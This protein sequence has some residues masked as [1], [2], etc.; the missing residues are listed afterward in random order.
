M[1]DKSTLDLWHRNYKHPYPRGGLRLYPAVSRRGESR[2]LTNV[3]D[4][5][6]FTQLQKDVFVNLFSE[7]QKASKTYD[8]IFLDIDDS[9]IKRSFRL[10][11]AVTHK[12]ERNGIKHY[13]I[14]FSGSK[15]FH[16]YV[17]FELQFLSSYREA[18][19][20]WLREIDLIKYVD[21]SAIEHNRVTRLIGTEN[22]K[23][24]RYCIYL[25]NEDVVD[26]LDLSDIL[27]KA[28][29]NVNVGE[30]RLQ[31]NDM[32]L[33]QK[34]DMEE[35]HHTQHDDAMQSESKW[36]TKPE[37]YPECMQRLFHEA[38]QGTALGHQERLEMG[39]FLMHVTGQD[40]D[41]V[42][43]VYAKM[44]DYKEKVTRYQLQYI[45]QR[46]LKI[47]RCD[48]MVEYGICPFATK[49]EAKQQ[50]PFYPGIN[51]FVQLER[52]SRQ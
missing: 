7:D 43:K 17:P 46:D 5:L 28:K 45:Q 3:S 27:E 34:Y 23:S 47:S 30:L 11:L 9:D 24:G 13:N 39:K 1:I 25:G 12:L 22:M 16:V 20:G 41:T 18:I 50:C 42:V 40:I 52:K 15:G 19:L 51:K 29:G 35:R 21:V 14:T 31:F 4:V 26:S 8:C 32:R 33:L 44:S 10:L 36:F 48:S 2:Q 6:K 37:Q 38:N 49:A